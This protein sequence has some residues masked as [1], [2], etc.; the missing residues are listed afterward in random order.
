RGKET[1]LRVTQF[2]DT[3]EPDDAVPADRA[4][5]AADGDPSVPG[6]DVPGAAP[7]DSRPARSLPPSRRV[8]RSA[9]LVVVVVVPVVDPFPNI[10]QHIE[11]PE[12]VRPFPT[13]IVCSVAVF[14]QPL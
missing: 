3:T 5:P 2:S 11:Q 6:T 9:V 8:D 12:S 14:L 10:T 1:E 13:H 7:Q 4:V